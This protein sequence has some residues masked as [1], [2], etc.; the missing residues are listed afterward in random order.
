MKKSDNRRRI[1]F[2]E[3]VIHVGAGFVAKERPHVLDALPA[4]EPHLGR[5][6]PNDL[7]I[8]VTCRT[9]ATR[10]SAS[11]CA[12]HYRAVRRS[13]R[14]PITRTHPCPPRSKA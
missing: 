4:V 14:S 13:W 11:H 6:D 3:N 8:E 5:S 7:D 2:R 12:R 1:T 9:A 10:S